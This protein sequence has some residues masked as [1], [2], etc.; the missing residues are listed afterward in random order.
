MSLSWAC[1]CSVLVGS[2]VVTHPIPPP[3]PPLHDMSRLPKPPYEFGKPRPGVAARFEVQVRLGK[4]GK[5][6][7]F[8]PR[9]FLSLEIGVS[10]TLLIEDGQHNDPTRPFMDNPIADTARLLEYLKE[11]PVMRSVV[12]R[13]CTV[14]RLASLDVSSA[15][16]PAEGSI[17]TLSFWAPIILVDDGSK[18]LC[19]V[20][21]GLL[22]ISQA[23][24]DKALAAGAKA[25]LGD[26]RLVDDSL[27][28][29]YA[30]AFRGGTLVTSKFLGI[31]PLETFV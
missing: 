29:N 31:G 30:P 16:L 19:D 7:G 13:S 27:D 26:A 12:V 1:P 4:E 11:N 18:V 6:P 23:T 21:A 22:P 2:V 24:M 3:P 14:I 9:Y 15:G 17:I 20:T 25:L 5:L 8:V 10:N 28:S